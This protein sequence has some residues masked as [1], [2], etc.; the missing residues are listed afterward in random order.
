MSSAGTLSAANYGKHAAADALSARV[1]GSFVA[2]FESAQTFRD[3]QDQHGPQN[4][5]GG[6]G[7]R[8]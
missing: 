2:G 4:S 7:A 3:H 8:D 1:G 5:A 6:D